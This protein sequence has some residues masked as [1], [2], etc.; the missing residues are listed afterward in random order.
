MR[1]FH[2]RLNRTAPRSAQA[3]PRSVPDR[4]LER[5]REHVQLF[6]LKPGS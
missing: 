2:L 5:G 1:V 3:W 6:Q 4:H